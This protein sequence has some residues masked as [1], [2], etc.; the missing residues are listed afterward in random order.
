MRQYE[1][2]KANKT[3]RAK[4]HQIQVDGPEPVVLENGRGPETVQT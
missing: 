4:E 2:E 3:E 1:S